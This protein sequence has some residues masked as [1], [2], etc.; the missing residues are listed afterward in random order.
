MKPESSLKT[1][2]HVDFA[3]FAAVCLLIACLLL[4]HFPITLS[5]EDVAAPATIPQQMGEADVVLVIP[6]ETT[7]PTSFAEMDFSLAWYNLLTQSIG[8]VSLQLVSNIAAQDALNARWIIVPEKAANQFSDEQIRRIAQSVQRGATLIL[9]MPG[10]RWESLTALKRKTQGSTAMRHLTD[11]PNSPLSGTWRDALLNTPLE[12][13]ILRIDTLDNEKLASDGLLLEL[14][15]SIAHYRRTHGDGVVFVLAFNLGQ[16]LT[17]MVQ[18]KPGE[19]FKIEAEIPR[20]NALVLNDKMRRNPI[21]YADLI[22][23]HVLLSASQSSPIPFLWPFPNGQKS[24]LLIVHETGTL[25]DSAF[26]ASRYELDH[27]VHSTWLT[28][29][30]T[31]SK[32]AMKNA[33]KEDIG[34]SFLRPPAGRIYEPFGLPFFHPI[35]RERNMKNQRRAVSLR[36][37]E[38]V[39]TCQ[40]AGAHWE[41]Y[42]H[43]FRLLAAAG[44][45]IDLSYAPLDPEEYGYLFGTGFPFL[46]LEINGLL[47]PTYEIPALLSDAVGLDSLPATTALQLLNDAESRWHE[48]VLVKFNA[49]EM[50][51]RPTWRIPQTWTELIETAL[52]KNIGMTTVRNFMVHYTMR[53]QARIRSTYAPQ[54]HRLNAR[55]VLPDAQFQYTLAIPRRTVHGSLHDVWIDNA[56]MP[57]HDLKITGDNTLV[58]IPIAPGEHQVQAQYSSTP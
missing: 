3:I 54:T 41:H 21:P 18:G 17:A 26:A 39:S 7:T 9:E 37:G 27:Q 47:L 5:A 56:S 35:V 15:G 11:A 52:E 19:S 57:T 24:A 16:A 43:P 48:P 33:A 31:V 38:N 50:K 6:D 51:Q 32:D 28:T 20:T 58:L 42:T 23:S 12:T 25:G 14:D 53:K 8:P 34:V 36:R 4:H 55:V 30:G 22:K 49:D 13:P 40:I 2:F 1:R 45:Q 10:P 44:C 46:P 29:A